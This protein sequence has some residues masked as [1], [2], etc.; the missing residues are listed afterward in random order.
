MPGTWYYIQEDGSAAIGWKKING[1][2]YY[3]NDYRA[4]AWVGDGLSVPS[5]SEGDP[6]GDMM[7]GNGIAIR[8]NRDEFEVTG[9]YSFGSSGI[10][11]AN[12]WA[13]YTFFLPANSY[14]WMYHG[15]NGKAVK[16]WQKIDGNWYYFNNDLFMQTGWQKISGK[17]YYLGTNGIMTTG[18]QKVSGKWYYM[19]GSGVMQ[20]GWI[21]LSGK[22]Y[23][24]GSNGAMATGTQVIS[25][26]TYTFSSGGVWIK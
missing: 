24:L 10:M 26:K 5:S 9:V 13:K 2:W 25:G 3:F 1:N 14:K 22:W 8:K 7:T 12:Q 6:G 23:Y 17:W 19:A 20:T 21:K 18:W 4:C 16:G 11:K 15:A